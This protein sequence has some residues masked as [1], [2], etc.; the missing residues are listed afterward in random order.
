MGF[1]IFIS[2]AFGQNKASNYQVYLKTGTEVFDENIDE[3]KSLDKLLASS[4]Y[5]DDY[6]AFLQFYAIPDAEQ[7]GLIKEYGIELLE[8][9][10]QFVYLAAI[11]T[12]LNIEDLKTMNVRSIKAL[13]LIDKTDQRLLERPFPD[14]VWSGDEIKVFVQY[15]SNLSA[16][17]IESELAS[18]SINISSTRHHANKVLLTIDADEIESLAMSPYVRYIDFESDP[19]KAESDDGRNLHRSNMIDSDHHTGL[20]YDGTGVSAAIND[21]GFAGPHID[22]NGRENQSDVAN[23]FTGTHGDMTVG[24]VGSAGNIDPTM[25]G[26]APGAFLWVRSYNANMPNTEDL[27]QNEGVM[28]FSTSYSNGCNAG[29]TTVAQLVDEEIYEN[30][31]LMQVFSAGNSNGS[32]CGYGAGTEWGN[33]TGG[34][35]M[36]KNVIATANL[37]NDDALAGSSSRGPASDGRIK[38]DIA[39]HGQG[40]WSNAPDYEYAA[41]GGTSA[42]APGIAGVFTQLNHAYRDLN[43]G[44]DSP[45]ALLKASILNTAYD[46]GNVGPD[47][48]YGWGKVNALKAYETIEQNHYIAD[49]MVNGI[50]D[51]HELY[52]P[53]NV[54]ELRVM[55]YWHDMEGSTS[56]ASAL[57]NNIDMKIIDVAADVHY[58][59]VLDHT[60]NVATLDNP[61]VPGIDSI[62]NVEQIRIYDP[63]IGNH[64]IN[65]VGPFIPLG[66]VPYFIVYEFIYDEILVTYPNGGEG[67]VPGSTD[68][69]HW[70]AYG[71]AGTF[72]I[73]CTVD[74]GLTWTTLASNVAGD[75]RFYD[76]AVPASTANAKVRVSRS[77]VSDRSDNYFSIIDIPQ[78]I[79]VT[80][81]CTSTSSFRIMWD[82]VANANTYDVYLMGSMYMDS[83]MTVTGTTADVP[84]LNV[85]DD[86]WMSVRARGTNGEVGRRAIAV[87]ISGDGCLLDC[88]SQSD[89]G[90]DAFLSP[91]AFIDN[92]NGSAFD[93]VVN[94]I[95][96]GS[97]P[98]TGFPIAYQI[99]N[100]IAVTEIYTATLNG[101][102]S[103]PFSFSI[104][105]S[106]LSEGEHT[107]T[108]WTMAGSDGASCN[109]TLQ[110]TFEYYEAIT[111]FPYTEDFQNGPFPPERMNIINPD[112]SYTWESTIVTG[113][114]GLP[115][116][117]AALN[118]YNYAATGEEDYIQ[119]VAVD[120][121]NSPTAELTFDVA[122]AQFNTSYSDGLRVDISTD[123]GLTY[124]PVYFKEGSDLATVTATNNQWS[125]VSA[126][127]WRAEFVDL[128]AYGGAMVK[129]RF[130][131]INGYGNNLFIDNIMI[132]SVTQAPTAGFEADVLST[133][134]GLVNFS[135]LSANSPQQ[136]MWDFGDGG[137]SNDQ[138]PQ[139]TYL[140]DGTYDITLITSNSIGS[141]TLVQAAYIVVDYPDEPMVDGTFACYGDELEIIANGNMSEVMWYEAGTLFHEG[142]TI[143]SP[144]IT[145]DISY[146][147]QNI[148]TFASQYIGP[149]DNS[150][151]GGGI[152]SST[153]IGT[154]NFV[155]ERD[156]NIVS[157]WVE[158]TA[159]GD[160][161]F[162]LWDDIDGDG[163]IVDEVTV[164]IPAGTGR[165]DLNLY[166]PGAGVYSLGGSSVDMY[167]N[168][169]GAQYPYVL[170]GILTITGSSANTA[171]D[172]FYYLY[173]LEVQI[174]PCESPIV[175][176][177]VKY[178]EPDFNYT[179]DNGTVTFTD[180]SIGANNWTWD[181]G[182]GQTSSLQDP[183]NVFATTGT[184]TVMLTV[185]G[186]CA[187][188]KDIY[189]DVVG[190]DEIVDASH[191]VSPNPTNGKTILKLNK[192]NAEQAIVQVLS[193]DGKVLQQLILDAGVLE[194]ELDLSAL[195]A[196]LYYIKVRTKSYTGVSKVIV[197]E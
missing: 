197:E 174:P 55:V 47:F 123:C 169:S 133:C 65:I 159:A 186:D 184:Y 150:I 121:T 134:N 163:N 68:R 177:L 94:L 99:D 129:L 82:S 160:R 183:V 4:I 59:L 20:Q 32:D 92:C 125:P 192:I 128:S 114:N 69:I 17:T 156:F 51:I 180:N 122:H 146:Q 182:D 5:G 10:P 113:V 144:Q 14:W 21:D 140:S 45:S 6:Y 189:V 105:F 64:M 190:I 167:R 54:K 139:H 111:A 96:L 158:V 13:D 74:S 178:V 165:I 23:D 97:L 19:G 173:D 195:S 57:V 170:P 164:F 18:A 53:A 119:I 87:L 88:N 72:T 176:V 70:D 179:I 37:Y 2:G 149:I 101:G 120:L 100:H 127:H 162:Y 90:I 196:A 66:P 83:V 40:Q 181:F 49:T 148:E 136:W 86:Q 194:T 24:I 106:V 166:V 41:G 153:F 44:D 107:L 168:N 171:G 34:H 155:A 187:I 193:I 11:P 71:D 151:G 52:V 15:Q 110:M 142:D 130:A 95:N 157:A 42:A 75:A 138:N 26:M 89:A 152:H 115:T 39:A 81:V 22:F 50:T 56:A 43:N 109:D 131:S 124:T 58:P 76:F 7:S 27:H 35:K 1:G 84:V 85:N 28:V 60:P 191:S 30:P 48:K 38:P 145:A 80:A 126:S 93:V 46:L 161:T 98:Q 141:D 135:D 67:L 147:V 108:A 103:Q 62:N 117:A 77:L 118:F 154:S 116:T 137:S 63:A 79:Q 33:I 91:A 12:V 29:Y 36:G 143:T 8:Y 175:D 172:Y 102:G 25:R 31:S 73:E 78:N 9:I 3:L 16:A 104:P 185:D 132:E 61:A 188:S 112:D